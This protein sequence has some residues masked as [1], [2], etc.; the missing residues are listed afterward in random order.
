MSDLTPEDEALLQRARGANLASAEDHARVKRKLLVQVG[1]GVGIGTS[2]V[3]SSGGASAAL[4]AGGGAAVTAGGS[5]L[6]ALAAKVIVTVA[7]VGGA[8]TAVLV[9]RGSRGSA[10]VTPPA[11]ASRSADSTTSVTPV[12]ESS[13][14][15]RPP[16][17]ANL[18]TVQGGPGAGLPTAQREPVVRHPV[19]TPATVAPFAPARDDA[20]SRRPIVTEAPTSQPPTIPSVV[21]PPPAPAAGPSTLSAEADLLRAADAAVRAGAPARALAILDQHGA[22]FPS[23]ALVEERDAERV[24]VLCALG[25]TEEGRA[26]ATA[27]LRD[28]PRSPLAARVRASCGAR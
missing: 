12:L 15:E 16:A 14:A 7:L 22:R 19:P 6:I 8:T 13:V 1:L 3:S 23:G 2:A 20:P 4:G 9:V 21:A 26:A 25:R 10:V 27:F 24:V 28:R 5:G 17:T 18:D 11:V